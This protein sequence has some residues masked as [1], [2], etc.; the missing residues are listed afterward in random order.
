MTRLAKALRAALLI[1]GV[2]TAAH[3]QSRRASITDPTIILTGG[4][5]FTADSLRPWVE[6]VAIRGEVIDDIGTN[7]EIR[8]LAG[9]ETRRV[10][11]G[12]RV[13]VPGLND[14]HDHLGVASAPFGV[15][16]RTSG[17][18][19][20]G[21][22]MAEVIDSL[23]AVAARTP[24]GT[25]LRG[26]LG[27]RILNDRTARRAALDAVTPDH[28]VMLW[29]P[30]GHGTLVNSAAM[31]ALAI[32]E[33]ARDPAVGGWYERD[34]RGRLTGSLLEYVGWEAQRRLYSSAPD[35]T[36]VRLWRDYASD[37]L[38][39]GVTSVQ[40][41]TGHFDPATTVRIA[42]AA[43]LPLR[44]RII[45]YPMPN[46]PGRGMA[47]WKRVSE[48]PAQRVR[49]SGVKYAL[50]GTPLEQLALERAE[51][52][53][54]PG[55]HGRLNFPVDTVRAILRDALTRPEQTMLHVVGDSTMQ[56]V[57][58]MMESLAPDSVWRARRMRIEH[59]RGVTGEA[60]GRAARL[61]VVI[62]Q[63]REGAPLASWRAA[64][65]RVA[66]GSDAVPNPW[67]SVVDAIVSARQP[68]EAISREEA[69]RLATVG[70]AFA[71]RTDWEKGALT[72]GRDADLAVLSQDVFTVPVA[73][74]A[75]TRSVLTIVAGRVVH[76]AGVL[77]GVR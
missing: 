53:G 25:W 66:Y 17:D 60:I 37:R 49:V 45:P 31:R 6:A 42:R 43:A 14:A 57:L 8:R 47:E 29:A 5:I 38:Q 58:S 9:P 62:A 12:G 65:I 67:I 75:E 55:W 54:R 22:P 10:D 32:P 72:P 30:W 24:R 15:A 13:V 23:R 77:A 11:L 64:G 1:T 74:I 56:L 50:D 27:L 26:D 51:Y 3:A 19:I 40:A 68:A 63:P 20:A 76:D 69:V 73:S 41:M 39:Y 34:A 52:R 71:E 33:D 59:G 16:I 21:P 4:R 44:L 36:L 35:S 46:L 2:S 48:R 28:P 18:P 61:G 70:S 7:E